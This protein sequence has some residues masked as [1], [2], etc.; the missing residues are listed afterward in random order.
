MQHARRSQSC[1]LLERQSAA[2]GAAVL[3]GTSEGSAL[4]FVHLRRD[5]CAL[6]GLVVCPL[7]ELAEEDV[8]NAE[9]ELRKPLTSTIVKFDLL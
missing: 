7:V 6:D 4:T 8:S 9:A 5:I 3:L 1:N 2:E